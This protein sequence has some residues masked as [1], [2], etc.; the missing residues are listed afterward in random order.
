MYNAHGVS[1]ALGVSLYYNILPPN[2]DNKMNNIQETLLFPVRDE[3]ARKQFLI[4][5]LVVLAGFIIPILPFLLLMGYCAKIMRHIIDERKSPTMP[6]WEGS[7]W[8]A[9]LT[10]GVRLYG[11]QLVLTL[12]L[13]LVLGC[14]FV[15]MIGGSMTMS[16]AAYENADELIS[17]GILFLFFGIGSMI[18]FS[19]FSIPYGVII[20]AAGPHVVTNRSFAAAFQFKDWWAVFRRGLGQFILSYA[21]IMVL[22]FVLV[23]VMQIAMLT[24]VLMCV[25]PLIMIPYTAYSTLLMNTLYAQAYL[26]GKDALEAGLHATA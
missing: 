9:M 4:A 10:D 17:I 26:A 6:K 1:I 15:A 12:P 11:A 16:L 18:L 20:S 23:F 5:C 13:M 25:V 2:K 3:E 14:G 22:S 19:I 24:I 21:I 8:S 7:D